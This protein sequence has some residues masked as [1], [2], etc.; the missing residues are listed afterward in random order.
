MTDSIEDIPKLE[1]SDSADELEEMA[2]DEFCQCKGPKTKGIIKK[3]NNKCPQ[4]NCGKKMTDI[5]GYDSDTENKDPSRGEQGLKILTD[6][7]EGLSTGQLKTA[8]SR[9]QYHS[10][11]RIK[12]PTFKG[13]EDPAHFFVKLNNFVEI[14]KI[15][16]DEERSAI[17]KSCLSDEALDLFLSLSANEQADMQTLEKIFKQYFKLSKVFIVGWKL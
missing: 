14:N 12:P 8:K 13:N 2:D 7:L 16:K 11:V 1:E 4:P 17:L 6:W 3:N 10:S 5:Q 9:D 15:R